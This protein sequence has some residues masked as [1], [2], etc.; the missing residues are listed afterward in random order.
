MI[1]HNTSIAHDALRGW[2][3]TLL[4]VLACVAHASS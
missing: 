4:E 2:L 3:A 1:G